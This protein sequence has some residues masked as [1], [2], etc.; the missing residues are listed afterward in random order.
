MEREGAVRYRLSGDGEVAEQV[1]VRKA[2]FGRKL[3][4]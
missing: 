2:A 4:L 1:F 3:L